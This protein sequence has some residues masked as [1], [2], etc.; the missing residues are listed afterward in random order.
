MR[1]ALIN[2]PRSPWNSIL[3]HASD[4]ARRFIHKKLIGPPLGLLTLAAN[5][6]DHD[7][8]LLE[9]KGEYDLVPESPEPSRM[10]LDFLE[11]CRP[12]IVG[13]TFIA[14]EFDLGMQIMKTVKTFNP[15]ILTVAGGLHA[16]LCPGD[17]SH[18]AVDVIVKG[19]GARI[20]RQIVTRRERGRGFD[21]IESILVRGEDHLLPGPA[22]TKP[23]N[24]AVDDFFFPDR[25]LL[26][27]WKSTYIVGRAPGP[28]TYVYTSLGCPYTCSFCSIWP[29]YGRRFHQRD[30]ESVIQELQSLDGYDV[31]RFSDAN[32]LVNLDFIHRLFDRIGEENIRKTF[33]MD[34]R[35]DT[36]A[37]NPEL[38]EKLANG[39]LR[40]VI[41]GF[42]SIRKRELERYNKQL[43]EKKIEK[44]I[45][46]FHQNGIML[47]GN[48]IIPTSYT[49][50]DFDEIGAYAARHKV[51]YAGYTILTPFPGTAF[52]T[53]SRRQIIDYDLAKYNMFNAVTRT[54]LE[55]GEFYRRVSD[56]WLIRRGEEII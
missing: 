16:T 34:I 4:E 50:D 33:I 15:R 8:F 29:Q 36:A 54:A 56:L 24:P 37:D 27:R 22:A 26:E 47:R 3:D 45:Q 6:K 31:V 48:Y 14:S 55:P 10:V 7:V 43:D 42:E 17:F 44:A 18:P 21:G 11:S 19:P 13:V 12:D 1:V 35:A 2:P 20:F 49:A 40:V 25:S 39:G 23:C 53:E 5:L 46:V 51:A 28:S 52:Y 32:T 30:V 41:T 38:I 9:M